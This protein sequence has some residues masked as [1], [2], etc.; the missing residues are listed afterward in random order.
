MAR[1]FEQGHVPAADDPRAVEQY[2]RWVQGGGRV[3]P[4]TSDSVDQA[5]PERGQLHARYMIRETISQLRH[6][7]TILERFAD[8]L[9][10]TMT[11]EA[12]DGLRELVAFYLAK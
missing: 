10:M 4:Q 7:A 9:P 12:E 8:S 1:S 6:R 5:S 2:L 11:P 3:T